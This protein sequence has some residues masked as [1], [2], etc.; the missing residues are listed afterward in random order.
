LQAG[1]VIFTPAIEETQIAAGKLSMG[2]VVKVIMR[3]R[4]PFWEKLR[5]PG[6]HDKTEDLK[7]LTY[8]HAPAQLLPT[9]WTQSPDNAPLIAGWAGG[10]R[11]EKLLL[12]S[13]DSL[14]DHAV[15]TLARMF[16]MSQSLVEG[17]LEE[18]YTHDWQ[19]DPLSM[20]AYSYIPLGGTAAQADLARPI[21]N[22]L[23]FAGEATN[24]EGHHGTVHGATA[25]GLRAAREI[26]PASSTS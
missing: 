3:F 18:F 8:I 24:T 1:T 14:L 17:Q 5:I 22:T 16:Q 21:E 9:W 11:V 19:R 6:E 12:E 13:D 25:S 26:L 10:S 20:G 4:E 2:H 15:E 7:G 23:F